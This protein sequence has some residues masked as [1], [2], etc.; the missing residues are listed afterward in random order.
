MGQLVRGLVLLFGRVLGL[1]GRRVGWVGWLVLW[2]I[3]KVVG[4]IL[5]P[6]INAWMARLLSSLKAKLAVWFPRAT[7]VATGTVERGQATWQKTPRL[8]KSAILQG[9]RR[10]VKPLLRRLLARVL[11]G[12]AKWLSD[13]TGRGLK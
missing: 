9:W 3:G 1:I 8:I 11:P 4:P 13:N 6:K 10:V 2:L 12:V 5:G 7:K